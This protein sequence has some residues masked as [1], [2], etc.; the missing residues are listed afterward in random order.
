MAHSFTCTPRVH[1]LIEST[2]PA[3]SFPAEA[4][5]HLQTLQGWKAVSLI[6]LL[7]D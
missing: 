1:P 6:A 5:T 3:F 4:D 2:I 7:T